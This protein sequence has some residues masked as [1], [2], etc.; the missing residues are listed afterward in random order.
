MN[1]QQLQEKLAHLLKSRENLV[2][3]ANA[4]L[5]YINGQIELM[6]ELLKPEEPQP[7]ESMPEEP[8]EKK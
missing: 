4:R 8:K 1:E 7:E 5:A 6:E 3:E 2:N